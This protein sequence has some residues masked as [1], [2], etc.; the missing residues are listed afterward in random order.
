MLA[1]FDIYVAISPKQCETWGALQCK[2][3]RDRSR[4]LRLWLV[5][6]RDRSWF[7][8]PVL[9]LQRDHGYSYYQQED[10]HALSIGTKIRS[11]NETLFP[12]T[13]KHTTGK[14]TPT[15]MKPEILLVN[16]ENATY[17]IIFNLKISKCKCAGDRVYSAMKLDRLIIIIS[18]AT[19]IDYRSPAKPR[20][21]QS[22][23][24]AMMCLL[25]YYASTC[26]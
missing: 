22:K 25:T 18:K 16:E 14:T 2:T 20:P 23:Y 21:S 8:R 4:H 13:R 19:Y 17:L 3:G 5:E 6:R 26:Y 7:L 1:I 12:L 11:Y 24:R 9:D 15:R 10:A